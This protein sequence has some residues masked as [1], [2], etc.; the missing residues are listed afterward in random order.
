MINKIILFGSNGM[1]GN[2]VNCFF[3]QHYSNLK[4]HEA[5]IR[6]S[7][8]TLKDVEEYLVQEGIDEHT[9]VINCA[10]AIPQRSPSDFW[11]INTIF[12]HILA[13]ICE[14]Y[15][16]KMIHP[17]TDCVFS[18]ESMDTHGYIE[19]DNPDEKGEYGRSKSL[20]E[21]TSCTVIRTSIIGRER[22]NKKSF[23]EWIC[24][25]D[26]NVN[27]FKNHYWNGI[28]CLQWCK[29]VAIIIETNLFWCG[30]RHIFSP[31]AYSKYEMACMI[32]NTFN[33]NG[34]VQPIDAGTGSNKTLNTIYEE[35]AMFL[36]PDLCDQIAEL[37]SPNVLRYTSN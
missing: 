7:Q 25:N 15:G 26:A 29:I 10:G 1:L 12:P 6:I 13:L 8:S 23:M 32:K 18:G 31:K 19:T 11:I 33:L 28:T 24:Q 9:C 4:L 17:T 35:N 16:A 22:F 2:Y 3:R 21:P 20:G 34:T 27:G 36:I 37:S 30:V 14:R 5:T